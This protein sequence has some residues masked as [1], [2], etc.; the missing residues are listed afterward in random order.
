MI[1]YM[2]ETLYNIVDNEFNRYLRNR[3]FKMRTLSK[4]LRIYKPTIFVKM[5]SLY[6]HSMSR[7]C[8][9]EEASIHHLPWRSV[10]K[11]D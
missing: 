8:E 5:R 3:L 11:S 1:K 6:L 2:L 10:N 7:R 4:P 9:K